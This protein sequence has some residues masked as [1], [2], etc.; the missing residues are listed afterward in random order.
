MQGK[1]GSASKHDAVSTDVDRLLETLRR[2]FG[3]FSP[4]QQSLARYLADHVTELPLLSAQEVAAAAHCSPATVVR[5][6]Q[7]LGFS[8][9]PAVQRLVRQV[10]RRATGPSPLHAA[11]TGIAAN[12]P[13]GRA[14]AADRMS[15]EDV[16]ERLSAAGLS[17]II[18]SLACRSPLL[19]A[20]EGHARPVIAVLEER[21]ARA[22]RAL[23]VVESL[24]ARDRARFAA[25]PR[26]GAVIAVGI[27]RE[28][29]VAEAA[30]RAASSAGVPAG[31]LVDSALSPL[32]RGGLCR[33]VPADDRA[34]QP[35]LVAMVAVAQALAAGIVA[36]AAV[37]DLAAAA[38]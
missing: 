12:D 9:Y 20:G 5:F 15:L 18:A 13:V 16:S 31:V 6:A 2:D 29:T 17:P 28:I 7:S 33:V 25:L 1:W 38:N 27:G 4:A 10:Q 21:L 22:G 3:R 35:G 8:G 32:A 24:S 36:P 37:R 11:P 30:L 23:I 26:S 34:G 14:L 19:L